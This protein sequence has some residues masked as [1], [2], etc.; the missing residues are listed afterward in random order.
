MDQVTRLPIG[1][2]QYF[3]LPLSFVAWGYRKSQKEKN[4]SQKYVPG[5]ASKPEIYL[6]IDFLDE[7][8]SV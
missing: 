5:I 7:E 1:S 8:K 4:N 2:L 3:D 6:I